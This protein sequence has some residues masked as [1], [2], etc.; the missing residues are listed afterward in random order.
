[1]WVPSE[2]N[3]DEIIDKHGDSIDSAIFSLL[4]KLTTISTEALL[5]SVMVS[6]ARK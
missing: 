5:G 6:S 2:V 3:I 4:S 1:M